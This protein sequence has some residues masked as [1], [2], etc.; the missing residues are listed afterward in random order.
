MTY[1][2]TY[3]LYAFVKMTV[4]YHTH[5]THQQIITE[6]RRQHPLPM[7]PALRPALAS[8]SLGRQNAF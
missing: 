2:Y 1:I 4:R 8:S 3:T 5:H 7:S 6:I